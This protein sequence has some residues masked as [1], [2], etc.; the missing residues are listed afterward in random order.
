MAPSPT[1]TRNPRGQGERLR[2]ALMDAA[3]ELLLELGD[4]DKLDAFEQN[5]ATLMKNLKIERDGTPATNAPTT[6]SPE[7]HDEESNDYIDGFTRDLRELHM[8]ED[9]ISGW[10][11]EY[12]QIAAKGD[13][14]E[15][16]AFD[17]RLA[18][19]ESRYRRSYRI[20]A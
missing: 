14:D 18:D 5:L 7:S 10:V 9:Q 1:R 13:P 15:L 3:R 11:A 16:D 19:E 17:R 6:K 12:R 2:A 20:A 4:Q 8:P